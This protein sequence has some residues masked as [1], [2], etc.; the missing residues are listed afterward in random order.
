MTLTSLSAR[1]NRS[2]PL[3][4]ALGA[5]FQKRELGDIII[6]AILSTAGKAFS[7]KHKEQQYF[8]QSTETF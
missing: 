2:M 5:A 6:A 4:P 3:Q 7:E 1:R 8:Q